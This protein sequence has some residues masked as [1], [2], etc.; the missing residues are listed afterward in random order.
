MVSHLSRFKGCPTCPVISCSLGGYSGRDG[1]ASHDRTWGSNSYR[2]DSS[3]PPLY[4]LGSTY[5]NTHTYTH[6]HI[7]VHVHAPVNKFTCLP[8]GMERVTTS[9][10]IVGILCIP[11]SL[12]EILPIRAYTARARVCVYVHSLSLSSSH[13]PDKP[14]EEGG[15]VEEGEDGRRHH[16]QDKE[17]EAPRES[18]PH[19][20]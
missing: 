18:T 11:T 17:P 15:H 19:Q 5:I 7:H 9:D 20:G 10:H 8:G 13:P 16:D 14:L 12:L 6:I 3:L 1:S 4:I 2:G